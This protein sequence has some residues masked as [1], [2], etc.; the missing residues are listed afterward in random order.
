MGVAIVV[1][2]SRITVVIV[3]VDMVVTVIIVI[4]MDAIVVV[5]VLCLYMHLLL[6]WLLSC[7]SFYAFA[8]LPHYIS[9]AF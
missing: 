2:V 9:N 7:S 5:I 8:L 4:V 1:V 3:L 6:S